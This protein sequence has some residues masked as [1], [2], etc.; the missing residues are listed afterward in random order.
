MA[1]LITS[2]LSD[3]TQRTAESLAEQAYKDA[4]FLPWN[5]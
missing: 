4:A 3:P 1:K 2:I 5:D